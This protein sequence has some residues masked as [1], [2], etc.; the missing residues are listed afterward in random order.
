MELIIARNPDPDSTLPYLMRLPI[1][2]GLVFRTKD[3]WPRNVGVYATRFPS[4][5]GRP[6]PR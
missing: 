3:T 2:D 1:G 5:S 6:I 4:T